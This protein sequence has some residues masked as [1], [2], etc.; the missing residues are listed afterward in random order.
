MQNQYQ[1]AGNNYI[2]VQDHL[3]LEKISLQIFQQ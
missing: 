3:H 1:F 2:D